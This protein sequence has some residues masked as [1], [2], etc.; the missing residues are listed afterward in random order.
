VNVWVDAD[1]ALYYCSGS[2][3]YGKTPEGHFAS[4]RE[5]QQQHFKPAAG[6]ACQ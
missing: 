4:Q 1:T 6:L 3:L 5:A 2:D